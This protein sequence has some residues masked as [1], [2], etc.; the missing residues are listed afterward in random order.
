LI[1]E[2]RNARLAKDWK[3]ADEIRRILAEKKII[4]QDTPAATIWK[5]E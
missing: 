2:R 5:I 3:R 4:I 1:E